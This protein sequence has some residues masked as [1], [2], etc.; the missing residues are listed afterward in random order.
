MRGGALVTF[1]F[2]KFEGRGECNGEARKEGKYL[3]KSTAV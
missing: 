3:A 1:S 2:S